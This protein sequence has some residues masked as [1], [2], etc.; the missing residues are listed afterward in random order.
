LSDR[1]SLISVADLMETRMA[2]GKLKKIAQENENGL[3]E[4]ELLEDDDDLEA[5]L[6]MKVEKK[7]KGQSPLSPLPGTRALGRDPVGDPAAA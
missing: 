3:R 2:G 1:R 7:S 4:L 5:M 6:G